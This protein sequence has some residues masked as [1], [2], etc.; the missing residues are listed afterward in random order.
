MPSVG[1]CGFWWY[2]EKCVLHICWCFFLWFFRS[3]GRFLPPTE[4]LWL[5]WMRVGV[6]VAIVL[7]PRLRG[8]QRLLILLC[9]DAQMWNDVEDWSGFHIDI[10]LWSG[11]MWGCAWIRCESYK[12]LL[13]ASRWVSG[14]GRV[15]R[16]A[17]LAWFTRSTRLLCTP[18]QQSLFP[19]PRSGR[20]QPGRGVW[21]RLL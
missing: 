4:T 16:H 15:E 6:V 20:P 10:R 12:Q 5:D 18:W 14:L 21:D 9:P 3:L 8:D 7:L 13:G 1:C 2:C 17:C 11:S 19:L